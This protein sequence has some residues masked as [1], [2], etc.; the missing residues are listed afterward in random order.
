MAPRLKVF[1]WSDGFHAYTVAAT[2]RPK[3]LAAWGI[4]QDIFQS[5][6]AR[7][8][9]S[10]PDHDAALAMPG[11]VVE[12]GETVDVGKLTRTKTSVRAGPDKARRAKIER[13]ERRLETL[14]QARA[15]EEE[16]LA[17]EEAALRR[18]VDQV[19]TAY[20]KKRSTLLRELKAARE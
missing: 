8:I 19:Q 2:S 10:G 6:L 13:L 17:R 11:Q 16:D 20:D 18:R 12:R 1:T 14:D 7:E 3:A 5:G 15:D 4:G 9:K